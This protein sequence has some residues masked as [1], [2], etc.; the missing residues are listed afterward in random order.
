MVLPCGNGLPHSQPDEPTCTA[1]GAAAGR[2]ES[3]PTAQA[4]APIRRVLRIV[5]CPSS[6]D[7]ELQTGRKRASRRGSYAEVA[8]SSPMA[9][10]KRS[11]GI[12]LH[13]RRDGE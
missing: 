1:A 2:T 10:G 3:A 5:S 9:A 12:L 8:S 13:R 6:G 4:M 11:A 7:M